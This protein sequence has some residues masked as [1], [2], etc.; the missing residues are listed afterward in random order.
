MAR[1]YPD[2]FGYSVFPFYGTWLLDFCNGV[3]ILNAANADIHT[4]THKAVIMGGTFEITYVT[5]D[6]SQNTMVLTIDGTTI[7]TASAEQFRTYNQSQQG[8][9]LFY[10]THYNPESKIQVLS[11]T[12]GISFGY[13]FK[14]NMANAT[15][16]Q[17]IVNGYLYYTNVL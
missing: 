14:I 15:G 16:A 2:F 7:L 6:P 12:P 8:D 4:L 10:C 17:F 3:G 11:I 5:F 9:D 13:E 1:G